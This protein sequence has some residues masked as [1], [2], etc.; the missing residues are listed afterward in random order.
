MSHATNIKRND[1]LHFCENHLACFDGK[2]YG[3]FVASNADPSHH[4]YFFST[5][6]TTTTFL[7]LPE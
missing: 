6:T 5:I 1:T 4:A 7:L 3:G 2:R